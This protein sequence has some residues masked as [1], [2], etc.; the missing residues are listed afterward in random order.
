[1]ASLKDLRRR[2][3]P[4]GRLV[5]GEC[6]KPDLDTPLY[7]EFFFSF[8]KSFTEVTLDP[9]WRPRH[10][11]LTPEAWDEALKHAGFRRVEHTPPPRPLMD[12]HPS[13]SVG[14]M[15]ATA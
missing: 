8:I 1:E 13:F 12:E 15:C 2:L 4:G 9:R 5:I 11:F 3:K 7:L 14:A 10:G 6:L